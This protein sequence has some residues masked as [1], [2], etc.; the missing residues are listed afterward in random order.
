MAQC[1]RMLWSHSS[2]PRQCVQAVGGAAVAFSLP[3]GESLFLEGILDPRATDLPEETLGWELQL[4]A[5]AAV[6]VAQDLTQQE[7]FDQHKGWELWH[8]VPT[9]V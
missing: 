3:P 4:T 6:A 5:T 8:Q 7:L 1:P 9:K 2:R